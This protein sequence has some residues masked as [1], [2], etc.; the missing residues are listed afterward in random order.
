M[1]ERQ[2][3]EDIKEIK[4]GMRK[5]LKRFPESDEE[6]KQKAEFEAR[7]AERKKEKEKEGRIR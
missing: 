7:I 5:L 6:K 4:E 3:L 2:L 1:D